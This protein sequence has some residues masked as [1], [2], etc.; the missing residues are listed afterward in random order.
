M[1]DDISNVGS[2]TEIGH[3]YPTGYQA[4]V[5]IIFENKLHP[6]DE[7]RYSF[8]IISKRGHGFN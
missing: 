8:E 4:I 1:I 5:K 7:Y 3:E 2:A 6:F